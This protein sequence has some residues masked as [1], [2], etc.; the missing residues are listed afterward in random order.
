MSHL[1]SFV[2]IASM[3]AIPHIHRSAAQTL[4]AL[5]TSDPINFFEANQ[6]CNSSTH[7]RGQLASAHSHF[8]D[9]VIADLCTSPPCWIGLSRA[10]DSDEWHWIDDSATD[11]GFVL[12]PEHADYDS[13]A[14]Q[15]TFATSLPEAS[16]AC[17]SWDT[18]SWS[19]T[20]CLSLLNGAVCGSCGNVGEF[21]CA[22]GRQCT[23]ENT[24]CRRSR[25][26]TKV[27]A[28]EF[29]S[30]AYQTLYQRPQSNTP[31]DDWVDEWALELCIVLILPFIVCSGL[32]AWRRR[33]WKMAKIEKM[34]HAHQNLETDITQMDKVRQ[35]FIEL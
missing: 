23:G 25:C 11:Y 10:S 21:C 18:P 32:C 20:D 31:Y 5:N 30:T 12:D 27:A 19:D 14:A 7:R 15:P 26:A 24:E 3:V 17:A 35:E 9:T 4:F 8:D 33:Q 29:V 16:Q 22:E 1:R 28:T 34:R 6:Q 2:Y 13:D